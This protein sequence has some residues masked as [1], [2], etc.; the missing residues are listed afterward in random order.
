MPQPSRMIMATATALNMV[1]VLRLNRFWMFQNAKIPRNWVKMPT[2][3]KYVSS[4][5]LY[6]TREFWRV[7]IT[8]T[9][10]LRLSP[11]RK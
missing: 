4:S 1:F 6:A 2:R 11:S 8:V 7:A 9:V 10:V 5:V 3:S